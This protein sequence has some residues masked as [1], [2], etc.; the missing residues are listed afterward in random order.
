MEAAMIVLNSTPQQTL[1]R[2]EEETSLETS[3]PASGP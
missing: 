3:Y 1:F 2:L